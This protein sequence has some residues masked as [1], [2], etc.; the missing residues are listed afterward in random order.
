MTQLTVGGS[1]TKF[2]N[3]VRQL[4]VRPD[5]IDSAIYRVRGNAVQ[6][7]PA[8]NSAYREDDNDTVGLSELDGLR[9]RVVAIDV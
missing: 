5:D 7:I 8:D 6:L 1:S 4:P 2:V 3:Y 9:D